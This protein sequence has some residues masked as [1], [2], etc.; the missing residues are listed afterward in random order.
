MIKSYQQAIIYLNS[1]ITSPKDQ[2]HHSQKL[3]R[4][5]AI[6]EYLNNPQNKIKTIHIAGT[7]GKGSTAFYLSSLL[8]S[9]GFNVGLTLSPH[10]LDIRER[11]LINNQIILKKEFI[12]YLNQI[13]PVIKKIKLST[14]GSPTYFEILITL[15]FYI[16]AQKKL[17]YIIVETGIGGLLDCT[18]TISSPDKIAV[19]TK[20]GLDHTSILG[21]NITSIA[22]QK[23]G[24]IHPN[25]PVFSINQTKNA[26]NVLNQTAKENYTFINYICPQT[27]FKNIHPQKKSLVYDF[28]FKNLYISKLNIN[29]IGLYQVENSA[30]SLSVF[31]CLSLRDNFQLDISKIREV[32]LTTKF[33]GRAD[34]H[35]IGNRFLILDGAHNPQKISALVKSLKFFFPN[36]KFVFVL[37]YKRR[38]DFTKM[39]KSLISKSHQIIITNPVPTSKKTIRFSHSH[40]NI[41]KIFQQL[42]FSEYQIIPNQLQAFNTAIKSKKDIIITGSLYLVGNVYQLVKPNFR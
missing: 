20:F 21:P 35:Q 25:N 39:I 42:K 31:K 19:L 9:H 8:I 38:H 18:N 12:H 30:L 34:L 27:N 15:A 29:T 40:Q 10:L 26:Q 14:Y 41:I 16:F 13:V 28:S 37:A 32:F 5:T 22:T 3:T 2:S 17:D 33:Y 4:Q 6:L 1:F 36:Q 11:F 7:S 23:A 24:I